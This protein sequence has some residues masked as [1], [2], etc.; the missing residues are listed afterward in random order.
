MQILTKHTNLFS[1]TSQFL[2]TSKALIFY[3]LLKI[4]S[5]KIVLERV[6]IKKRLNK[7]CTIQSER[8]LQICSNAEIST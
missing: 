4:P 3:F 1:Q 2:S 7:L 6:E 8:N 5:N